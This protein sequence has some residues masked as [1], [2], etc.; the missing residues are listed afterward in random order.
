MLKQKDVQRG[1]LLAALGGT[2]GLHR[3]Y[4]GDP[5]GWL[6]VA[7]CWSGIPTVVGILE[8]CNMP[9][10]VRIHNA[11]RYGADCHRHRWLATLRDG[12]WA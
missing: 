4:L 9:R 5:R 10:R 3:F 6:Y 11:E 1:V 7:L 12:K 2:L 8:A